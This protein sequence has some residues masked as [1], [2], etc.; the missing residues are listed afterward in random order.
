M[1]LTEEWFAGSTSRNNSRDSKNPTPEEVSNELLSYYSSTYPVAVETAEWV[2]INWNL[3]N[4]FKLSKRSRELLFEIIEKDILKMD[5]TK[6][7][8]I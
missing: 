5:F 6:T 1:C 4:V 3:E 8:N 2:Y 7:N